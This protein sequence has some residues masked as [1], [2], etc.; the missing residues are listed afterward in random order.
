MYG[1]ASVVMGYLAD[2]F[3]LRRTLALGGTVMG[4]GC[5]LTA[6]VRSDWL[7]YLTWGLAVGVGVGTSYSP[8]AAAVSRWF[9]KRKGLTV[10]LVVSGLGL[11]TVIFPPLVERWIAGLGWRSTAVILGLI[12]WAVYF[13]TAFII[14]GHPAEKGLQ[15]LGAADPSFASSGQGSSGGRKTAP[16]ADPHTFAQAVRQGTFWIIFFVHGLWVLGMSMTMVHLVPYALDLGQ[17]AATAALM[18]SVIGGL[19][20]AGRVVLAVVIERLGTKWSLLSL[21]LFQAGTMFL[22]ASS[23][24][25]WGL[26]SFT[27]LFGFTYGGLASVFPLATSEF[28][29][30]KNMGAI[31]GVILL[32]ATLG[33]TVGPTLAGYVFDV[34]REY[35]LAFV[36]AGLAM[37]LGGLMS[38][39]IRPKPGSP[40]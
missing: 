39:L 23:S 24:Q 21:L 40:G 38:L 22:L 20:V 30:L 28:F 31:F 29:G 8:T 36:S 4:A 35:Y 10:G 26:W 32:G 9:I 17:P 12:V 27:L 25:A 16:A 1:L 37:I 15:P 14:R 18:L 33:G 34:T 6:L 13:G 11:G 19:S 7:L 5:L 3:G 2:R